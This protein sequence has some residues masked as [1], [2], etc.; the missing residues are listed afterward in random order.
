MT[1]IDD[2]SRCAKDLSE[3]IGK[4]FGNCAKKTETKKGEDYPQR[5][6]AAVNKITK[7]LNKYIFSHTVAYQS[8]SGP[9]EW[10][11]PY[12]DDVIRE[13]SKINTSA[14]LIVPLGFVTDHLETLHEL[15]IEYSDLAKQLGLN[16][17]IRIPVPNSDTEYARE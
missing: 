11:R 13:I 9:A 7:K 6:E 1:A 3:K 8:Q 2:E 15:D 5:I 16:N 4:G 17:Y 12:T 14:V 10:T